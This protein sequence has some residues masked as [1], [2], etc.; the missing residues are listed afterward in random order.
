MNKAFPLSEKTRCGSLRFYGCEAAELFTKEVGE[1]LAG[2]LRKSITYDG[3]S[4]VRGFISASVDGRV[5]SDSMWS[6]DVGVFLRELANYGYLEHACLILDANFSLVG[7]NS[8]GYFAFP[9]LFYRGQK[10]SGSEV[11]GTGAMVIGMTEMWK[12]LPESNE[13]RK[14]IYDF[15]T[16]P[17]SPL[18]Y[19]EKKLKTSPL[20]P[21]TGEFGAGCDVNTSSE[22]YNVVQNNLARLALL[23]GAKMAAEA[24][25]YSLSARFTGV[26]DMLEENILKYFVDDDGTWMWCIVSDTMKQK[27]E[28]QFARTNVG[29]GGINGVGAMCSDVLG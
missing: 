6:R 23:S 4:G 16:R 3:G 19:F 22:V 10:L 21:G 14:R 26:A 13:T 20:I 18:F 15:L 17:D 29:F 25:D 27:P 5:C 2:V 24:G 11:D 28:I 7:K 9:T 1:S 12:R 8:E